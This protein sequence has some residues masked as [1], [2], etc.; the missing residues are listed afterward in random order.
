MRFCKE[1]FVE[2]LMLH[3]VLPIKKLYSFYLPHHIRNAATL[4]EKM[5]NKNAFQYDAY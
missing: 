4:P 2:K 3:K 1:R 5:C